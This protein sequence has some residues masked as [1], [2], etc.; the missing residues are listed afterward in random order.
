MTENKQGY[1]VQG[2]VLTMRSLSF[3]VICILKKT[4]KQGCVGGES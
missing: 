4:N 3:I 2:I 1:G